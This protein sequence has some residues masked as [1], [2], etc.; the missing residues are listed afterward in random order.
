LGASGNIYGVFLGSPTQVFYNPDINSVVFIHRMVDNTSMVAFDASTDGGQTW[1]TE[2]VLTPVQTWFNRYPTVAI[3]NAAGNIDPANALV[4]GTGPAHDGGAD[5][6]GINYLTSAN[7][8]GTN[9]SEAYEVNEN[10]HN[11]GRW[12]SP[13]GDQWRLVAHY[14]QNTA[15][16][17]YDQFFLWK[18]VEA[19]GSISW[20][21]AETFTP[22]H[23]DPTDTFI[24]DW[25][26]AF[27]P[28]GTV[29]YAVMDGAEAGL[30]RFARPII[31]KTTDSGATWTKMPQFDL[32]NLAEDLEPYIIRDTAA[33]EPIVPHM[34]G[35]DIVVDANNKVHISGEVWSCT[36]D[37]NVYVHFIDDFPF[38]TQ[39]FFD[40]V[41]DGTDWE[42][43]YVA[44]LNNDD[45]TFGDV[46]HS[47]MFVSSVT[48]DGEILTFSW[49][50]TLEDQIILF[51]EI[52]ILSTAMHY[53]ALIPS[54]IKVITE[55]DGLQA[56]RDQTHYIHASPILI[57]GGETFDYEIPMI[58]TTPGADDTSP[59]SYGYLY[60]VGFNIDEIPE[61][62]IVT[63]NIDMTDAV[64][65]GIFD[66]A[67]EIVDIAGTMTEWGT[68]PVDLTEGE[69]NIW[70]V[71]LPLE[72][73]EI[74]YKFR[75]KAGEVVVWEWDG[76]PDTDRGYTVSGDAVIDHEWE[77]NVDI[78]TI[79]GLNEVNVYPNP[80][81]SELH[82][83]NIENAK[84][85][86]YNIV[87][88][89]VKTVEKGTSMTTI[90]MSA[91]AEGTYIVKI[92]S[93]NTVIS[94][95]INVVK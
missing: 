29:G 59:C 18:G 73:G 70:T 41:T 75:R 15:A 48:P 79:D 46:S 78:Y 86:I 80:V 49:N 5:P 53:T 14:V 66:P 63:F 21:L 17:Q 12:V 44:P 26:I 60:G 95:K 3:W 43:V 32:A 19:G 77:V 58:Y 25:D 16:Q 35:C 38:T 50:E 13:N 71:T 67:T 92:F 65:A 54:E 30:P 22:D 94:R 64:N 45:G 74:G 28:D 57:D 23:E 37:G 52:N 11:Y 62:F 39:H 69:N 36:P 90:D 8:D 24:N 31:W 56:V 10:F 47:H 87:G 91:L 51:N 82:I 84:V 20:T 88:A 76:I 1:T 9:V 61:S 27:G 85:N 34:H 40:F 83:T 42:A 89:L 72:A 68:N 81:N 6:W 93:E 55:L 4:V 7:L 33:G 2:N